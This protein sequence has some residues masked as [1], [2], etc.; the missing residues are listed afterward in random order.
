MIERDQHSKFSN[1]NKVFPESLPLKKFSFS[2]I[3]LKSGS[4][5]TLYNLNCRFGETQKQLHFLITLLYDV[6]NDI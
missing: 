4:F 6:F 1:F 3:L 5:F 2:V